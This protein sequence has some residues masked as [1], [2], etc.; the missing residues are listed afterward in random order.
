MRLRAL[1]VLATLFAGCGLY[2]GTP[3]I[4]DGRRAYLAGTSPLTE[5]KPLREH[6]ARCELT[7][8]WS[9]EETYRRC[10]KPLGF[11][12]SGTRCWVYMR[13]E[14][15]REKSGAKTLFA[16][17][18][19]GESTGELSYVYLSDEFPRTTR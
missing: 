16:A 13:G 5:E 8:G 1:M 14:V 3:F 19:F 2:R 18:C 17:A 6:V 4:G 11:Y 15:F 10:G 12:G 9:R 7:K